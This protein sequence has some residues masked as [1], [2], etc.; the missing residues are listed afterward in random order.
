M[1]LWYYWDSMEKSS[2]MSLEEL[3]EERRLRNGIRLGF[4]RRDLMA[5]KI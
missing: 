3:E 5:A 4:I 2:T 1:V